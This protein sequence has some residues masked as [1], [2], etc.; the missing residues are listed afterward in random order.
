MI[1]KQIERGKDT[2]EK[3]ANKKNGQN[4]VNHSVSGCISV[5]KRRCACHN[6]ES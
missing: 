1:Q 3:S 6:T 4:L 2:Y 5:N